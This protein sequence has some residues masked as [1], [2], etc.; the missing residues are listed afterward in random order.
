MKMQWRSG[1]SL[2]VVAVLLTS[3]AS[4]SAFHSTWTN[5]SAERVSLSGKKV[6]AIVHVRSESRRREAEDALAVAISARGGVGVP[7]YTL[8]PSNAKQ[9]DEAVAERIATAA[10]FSGMVM[11]SVTDRERR[12]ASERVT[13][14]YWMNDRY[15][16]YPWG[17]WGN[18]W[19]S[20]WEPTGFREETRVMVDTR[21]YSIAQ[22]K[23]LWTGASETLNPESTGDVIRELAKQL[24]K[25]LEEAGILTRRVSAGA[26]A[27]GA[28]CTLLSEDAPNWLRPRT[29]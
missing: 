25:Q 6:L 20:M 21:V 28:A 14:A 22:N 16:Q 4:N 17:A 10:G 26:T 23:L 2:G 24:T 18:G 9:Q 29:A 15:Y 27:T 1:T 19:N 7:S 11:M 5:P 8:L 3:C 12:V 13:S